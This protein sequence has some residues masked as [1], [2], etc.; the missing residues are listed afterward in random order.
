MKRNDKL[1]IS[2]LLLFTTEVFSPIISYESLFLI[3]QELDLGN[4][5]T[6]IINEDQGGKERKKIKGG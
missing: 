1:S 3:N 2:I 6:I 4:G 5:C